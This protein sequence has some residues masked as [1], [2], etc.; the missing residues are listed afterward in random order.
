[1]GKREIAVASSGHM[2]AGRMKNKTNKLK[3]TTT[4]K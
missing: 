3:K 1:M 4:T 2:Q